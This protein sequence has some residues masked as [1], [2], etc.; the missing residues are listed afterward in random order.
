MSLWVRLPSAD[1]GAFAQA[2]LRNGVAVATAAPL[3]SSGG[4]RDRLRLSFSPAPD[5]L[6]EGVRRLAATWSAVA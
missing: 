1:A 2:A 6:E 3:S 4:H 5:A